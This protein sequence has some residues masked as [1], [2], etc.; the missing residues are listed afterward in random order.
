LKATP[1]F[2][3][4]CLCCLLGLRIAAAHAAQPDPAGV[5][6][7]LLTEAQASSALLNRLVETNYYAAPASCLQIKS[8]GL[9][10]AGYTLEILGKGCPGRAD[11]LLGRWRVDAKSGELFVQHEDG[12]YRAPQAGKQAP[13]QKSPPPM[14]LD[15]LAGRLCFSGYA[16]SLDEAEGLLAQYG[17]ALAP[18]L[19]EM[20]DK[21]A[22]CLKAPNFAGAFPFNAVWLL[23]HI[24]DQ[25]SRE[26]LERFS[27]QDKNKD[28]ALA[29]RAM[30][31]RKE[32]G[33][34]CGVVYY[35]SELREG[36]SSKTKALRPLAPGQGLRLLRERIVNEQEEGPRGGPSLYDEVELI[37][38]G[39]KGF[40][41]RLGTGDAAYY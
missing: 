7:P 34:D 25:T 14:K 39:E 27:R 17:A 22:R 37:P 10:N 15:E 4:C 31:L 33:P 28:Y 24:G 3:L 6:A 41:E 16:P 1:F 32:K 21:P 36:P 8:Q 35:E 20:L 26:A 23:A 13:V 30:D 5:G 11:G 29:L 2:V 19:A 40:V 38:S 12:K 18:L 9:K